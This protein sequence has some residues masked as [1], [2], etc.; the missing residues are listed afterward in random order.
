[1]DEVLDHDQRRRTVLELFTLVH[2]DVEAYLAAVRADPFGLGQ[3][4][5]PALAGQ[6]LGQAPAAMRPAPPRG[7]GR[8]L[9]WRRRCLG[10]PDRLHEQQELVRIVALAPRAVQAAQQPVEPVPQRLVVAPL[11]LE[12]GE[13]LQDQAPERGHVVGQVLG[14]R[15]RQASG[16]G[17]RE[18]HAYI[19]E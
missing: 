10:A 7:L 3:L 19:I 14:G 15:R 2:A 5:M 4:V 9:G 13:Q 8:R 6:V 17:V 18:A 11:L 16:S 12:C 1:V